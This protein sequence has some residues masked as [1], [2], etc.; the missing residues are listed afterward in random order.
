MQKPWKPTKTWW[1]AYAALHGKGEVKPVTPRKKPSHDEEHEQE[2]FNCWF[3][4]Y[5]EPKGY[6]WFHPANGGKRAGKMINGKWVPLEGIKL[7]RL[8]V[9]KGVPDVILP[10][11]RKSYHGLVIEF[12]RVDGKMSDVSEEQADW[13]RWFASQNWSTHV[14]FGFEAA[15]RIVEDYF[16]DK[17]ML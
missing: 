6:R 17:S 4:A 12:K 5:L 14:A 13:L 7:K 1:A 15:K 10:M 11:A 8:G 2:K 16:D 3:E 9:K